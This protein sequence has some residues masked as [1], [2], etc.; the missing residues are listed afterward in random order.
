L[1][2]WQ[3]LHTRIGS[4]WRFL[5]VAAD[6]AG[7]EAA[8]PWLESAGA[9]FSSVVDADGTLTAL[10]GLGVVSATL[11]FDED[12]RLVE[13]ILRAYPDEPEHARQLEEWVAGG[14]VPD[15]PR[16]LDQD[17][18]PGSRRAL[19]WRRMAELALAEDDIPAAASSLDEAWKLEPDNMQARKQRWALRHPERFYAGDIDREWQRSQ[20]A[21]GG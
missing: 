21:E 19:A 6:V 13:P 12:T 5:S 8:Q 20:V 9:T 4:S 10:F 2:G 14:P 3:R 18:A 1:P 11:L 17:V 15:I 7:P 16:R